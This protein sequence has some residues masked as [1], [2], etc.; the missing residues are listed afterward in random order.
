MDQLSVEDQHKRIRGV[1]LTIEERGRLT[2]YGV[3]GGISIAFSFIGLI[4]VGVAHE[5][6][7][8]S[9][10]ACLVVLVAWEIMVVAA[11]CHVR[12]RMKAFLASVASA[13]KESP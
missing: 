4:V 7:R 5:Q 12:N 6:L 8:L 3:V 9:T 13:R 2:R 11:I 1:D 10:P